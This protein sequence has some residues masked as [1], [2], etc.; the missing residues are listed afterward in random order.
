MTEHAMLE[1]I[2][3]DE[4]DDLQEMQPR[5]EGDWEHLYKLFWASRLKE[6]GLEA[7]NYWVTNSK[8][9]L[10]LRSAE[11]HGWMLGGFDL[12]G[13]DLRT[14]SFI[15]CRLQDVKFVGCRLDHTDFNRARCT[16]ADF[17]ETESNRVDMVSAN[18]TGAKFCKAHM[19]APKLNKAHGTDSDWRE[20]VVNAAQAHHAHLV[21]LILP[22]Q[23]STIPIFIRP[24]CKIANFLKP[25]C[26]MRISRTV[27]WINQ[28]SPVLIYAKLNLVTVLYE[29]RI[30]AARHS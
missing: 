18:L 10:D 15:N 16:G 7:W 28:T 9:K 13:A 17:S 25:A 6:R 3:P 11:F 12:S 14:A 1:Y 2:D 29:R 19:I 23:N 8:P 26:T 27:T 5:F 21:A 30:S 20:A 4:M 24:I 22:A